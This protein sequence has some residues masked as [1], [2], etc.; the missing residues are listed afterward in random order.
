MGGSNECSI[1]LE[2][3][4]R[5]CRCF[6]TGE[7]CSKQANIRMERKRLHNNN[8]I[9]AFVIMNF[10]SMSDVTFN[11]RLQSFIQSVSRNLEMSTDKK[12]NRI[13]TCYANSSKKQETSQDRKENI[14]IQ[15]IRADSESSS[16]FVMCS[17]VCQ[18]IQMADLIV[19]DVSQRN[20]NVFYELGMAVALGKLILPICYSESF[21]K[22][23]I[24]EELER[25]E[26]EYRSQKRKN[27]GDK[28]ETEKNNKTDGHNKIGFTILKRHIDCYPWRRTLFEHY[29]IRFRSMDDSG[30]IEEKIKE[31]KD[32]KDELDAEKQ[33]KIMDKLCITQYTSYENAI[34]EKF[35][36]SDIQYTRF[37]YHNEININGKKTKM[38]EHLYDTLRHSYNCSRYEHN[39]LVV[40]TM[41]GFLN[42]A[43]AGQCIVNYYN[44][45]TDRMKSEQCFYGDRVGVLVQE[46]VIPEREKDAKED[47]NILYSV[48]EIIHI[49][50]NQ[51]TAAS[52]RAEIHPSDYPTSENSNEEPWQTEI[53]QFARAYAENKSI[54]IYPEHPVYARRVENGIQK[55]LLERNAETDSD[56]FYNHYFCLYHV[57]LRN[58]RY[59]N[60]LVVDISGN[61]IQALFWLGAAHGSDVYAIAVLHEES[62]KERS[63][64]SK[65]GSKSARAIFDISGLWTAILHSYDTEGFYRQLTQVQMGIDQHTKPML[66]GVDFYEDDLRSILHS[67][68]KNSAGSIEKVLQ[69]KEREETAVLEKYYQDRF[70]KNMLR[71]NSLCIYLPQQP[72]SD[73]NRSDIL[74]KK[75]HMDAVANIFRYLSTR[76]VIGEYQQTMLGEKENEKKETNYISI[77][78]ANN[79]KEDKL[80]RW[81]SDS[82][83]LTK[84][85]ESSEQDESNEFNVSKATDPSIDYEE[86]KDRDKSVNRAYFHAVLRSTPESMESSLFQAL[87]AEI[88]TANN[89]VSKTLQEKQ[90]KTR[91]VFY[92]KFKSKCE[93]MVEQTLRQE[94]NEN[95]QAI[96][97]DNIVFLTKR[98]S[99]A[100]EMYLS[101][102]LYRYFL[103]F[104]TLEEEHRIQNGM[105][106]FIRFLIAAK[107]DALCGIINQIVSETEKDS[108]D[109][110][111][112]AI[113]TALLVAFSQCVVLEYKTE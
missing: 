5:S 47:T 88:S 96:H 78:N 27:D 109:L 39:T 10:S 56:F 53:K 4:C 22:M 15:I 101:T 100:A 59:T 63:L 25:A 84:P 91:R 80:S 3:Y 54:S 60:E 86:R 95:R 32:A 85:D 64:L 2:D 68:P 105:K 31:L 16:N 75:R 42:E 24:P 11:G 52:Q 79:L 38:G 92:S 8:R 43:Q 87:V 102:V 51:A 104:L 82:G 73:L 65:A 89:K 26:K 6:M 34:N 61:S 46:N 66:R 29:G 23:H 97:E 108:M 90:Q 74:V 35:G 36:F 112:N 33:L 98:I 72:G 28:T 55:D 13:L 40:Y 99:Y 45:I 20:T 12:G 103:P 81:L 48:G 17:R 77:K 93:E 83:K 71:Y 30:N 41:D 113:E 62:E 94:I 76:T 1:L 9:N 106:F 69:K 67:N 21:Y 44:Y 19:V 107:L 49:G 111:A 50:M 37:P 7:Y 70:W 18:Q 58:L 110:L 57:M 14:N